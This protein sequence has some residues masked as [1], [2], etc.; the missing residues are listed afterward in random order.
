MPL[1]KKLLLNS[2]TYVMEIHGVVMYAQF[3]VTASK[4]WYS[5]CWNRSY[6]QIEPVTEKGS[7]E[8]PENTSKS[9]KGGK[10]NNQ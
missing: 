8:N 9:E 5:L 1:Y 4:V 6:R 7:K 3:L 10:W 2:E